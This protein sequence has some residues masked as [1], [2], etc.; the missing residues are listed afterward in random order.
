MA[1]SM[2]GDGFFAWDDDAMA[3]RVKDC[4]TQVEQCNT[5]GQF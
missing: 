5:A 1:S 2:H 4:V 3:H